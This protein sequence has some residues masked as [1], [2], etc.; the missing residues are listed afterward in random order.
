VPIRGSITPLVTPLKDGEVD[1][2][3][4]AALVERQIRAG[5]HGVTVAGT[6]GE[7]GTLTLDER[8]RLLEVAV[9][10]AAGRLPVVAGTGTGELRSTMRLT[11]HASRAGADACLVVTPYYVKPSQHGLVD[12]FHTVADAAE[13]PVILYDIPGRSGVALALPTIVELAAHPNIVGVK[14]ARADLEHASNVLAACGPDFAL[15]C[16]VETLCFPMLAIGGSGHMAATGNVAPAE[17][18]A[19]AQCAFDGDWER[20]RR[21]HYELL[22]LNAVVFADTNPV[23]IKTMLAEM[24]LIEFGVR[25][26]LAA[27]L[28]EV[29]AHI[30]EVLRRH[31]DRLSTPT[32]K[33]ALYGV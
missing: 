30:L 1:Y 28:P 23:P 20:A 21:L 10:T 13:L 17:M 19:M 8:E 25:S 12:Y 14:E 16:G 9:E 29:R 11:G 3:R 33:E 24:G 22:E 7:P 4:F 26:P 15:Y 32:L 5:G 2:E 31:Q 6:T 27:P 18:A